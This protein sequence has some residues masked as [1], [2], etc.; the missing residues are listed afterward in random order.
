MLR[1]LEQ[2]SFQ[3]QKQDSASFDIRDMKT[4]DVGLADVWIP[5]LYSS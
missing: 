3:Q 4:C 5:V 1:H 2:A